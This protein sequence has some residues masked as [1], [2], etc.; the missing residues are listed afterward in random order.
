M[1]RQTIK[2]GNLNTNLQNKPYFLYV[3]VVCPKKVK[4]KTTNLVYYK[5]MLFDVS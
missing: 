2:E 4:V 3:V 1:H 5:V